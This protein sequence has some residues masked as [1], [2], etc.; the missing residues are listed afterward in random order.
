MPRKGQK[1]FP[2]YA[3][4]YQW[5]RQ[6]ETMRRERLSYR[7]CAE[8]L[9]E[10]SG[11]PVTEMMCVQKY[12]EIRDRDPETSH[13][14]IVTRLATRVDQLKERIGDLEAQLLE[15]GI[16]PEGMIY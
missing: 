14:A 2:W 15:N 10:R 1:L 8:I 11:I 5:E 7:V 16:E 12:R 13:R 9:T 6:L 4:D 3:N